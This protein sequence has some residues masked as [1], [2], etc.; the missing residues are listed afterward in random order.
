VVLENIVTRA[1]FE[2]IVG[3]NALRL[4]KSR[5]L[6]GFN[7]RHYERIFQYQ[8]KTQ[9][10]IHLNRYTIITLPDFDS[11]TR[12]LFYPKGLNHLMAVLRKTIYLQLFLL[13]ASIATAKAEDS[14]FAPAASLRYPETCSSVSFHQS[15]QEYLMTFQDGDDRIEYRIAN[16]DPQV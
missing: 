10:L 11:D 16:M 8:S 4:V 3:L 2:S 9:R 14:F 12:E 5:A 13:L 1:V 7:K 15:R 6:S